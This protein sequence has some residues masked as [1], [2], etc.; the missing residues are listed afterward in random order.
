LKNILEFLSDFKLKNI[1]FL[2]D[3]GFY[4]TENLIGMKKK[5]KHSEIPFDSMPV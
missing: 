3:K 2:L 4:S 5:G 1:T